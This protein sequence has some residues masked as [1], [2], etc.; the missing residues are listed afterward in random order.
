MSSSLRRT[1]FGLPA[2]IGLGYFAAKLYRGITYG[3][4]GYMNDTYGSK[5]FPKKNSEIKQQKNLKNH[6]KNLFLTLLFSVQS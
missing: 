4:R 3:A 1:V 5:S 6:A 2:W